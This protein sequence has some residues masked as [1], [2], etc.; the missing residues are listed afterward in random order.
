MDNVSPDD[1][2]KQVEETVWQ[3]IRDQIPIWAL[4]LVGVGLLVWFVLILV[5]WIF[6]AKISELPSYSD[7]S[8]RTSLLLAIF[9][10]LLFPLELGP[11]IIYAIG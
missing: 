7:D 8:K 4:V 10:M 6:W 1:V 3:E 9:G 2:Q 5:G 11:P